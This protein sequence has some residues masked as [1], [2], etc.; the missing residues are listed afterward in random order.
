MSTSNVVL[1]IIEN[2]KSNKIAHVSKESYKFNIYDPP[3]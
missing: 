3:K 2:T 1:I